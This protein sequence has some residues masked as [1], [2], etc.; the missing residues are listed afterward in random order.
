MIGEI[1]SSDGWEGECEDQD[2]RVEVKI[3]MKK[4][5]KTVEDYMSHWL[6]YTIKKKSKQKYSTISEK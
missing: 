3:K 1:L 2:E 6:N 5:T 4:K